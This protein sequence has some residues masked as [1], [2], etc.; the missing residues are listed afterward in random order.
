MV[1]TVKTYIRRRRQRARSR[2]YHRGDF[3]SGRLR[4][5]KYNVRV[6]QRSEIA[7]LSGSVTC[8]ATVWLA[9]LVRGMGLIVT[10]T[11]D[12]R[13]SSTLCCKKLIVSKRYSWRIHK[14]V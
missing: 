1:V 5:I 4:H 10:R 13:G 6:N 2:Y 11:F 3:C 8:T 12:S 14:T 7:T 9:R